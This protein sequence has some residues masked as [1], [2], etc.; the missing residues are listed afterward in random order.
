MMLE[1]ESPL[2]LRIAFV[3][4]PNFDAM[5]LTVSPLTIV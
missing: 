3:V 2:A 1:A 4:T 5:R